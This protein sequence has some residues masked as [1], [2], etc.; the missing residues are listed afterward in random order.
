MHDEWTE[1]L[2]EYL[3]DELSP[4]ERRAVEEHLA[5]C[6]E[7][8][9][10]L[11]ELRQVVQKARELVARPPASDLWTGIEGAL[12]TPRGARGAAFRAREERFG[13]E[14]TRLTMTFTLPQLAAA[15]IFLAALSAGVA[16]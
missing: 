8:A 16:A 3:D 14:R 9:R 2:S 7:C 5:V 11:D 4:G 13:S 1:K 6:T 15:S 10:A 12:D